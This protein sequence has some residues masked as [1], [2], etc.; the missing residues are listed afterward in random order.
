M[1]LRWTL[2]SAVQGSRLRRFSPAVAILFALVLALA[3]CSPTPP[4]L[5][6]A[7]VPPV[8]PA[9]PPAGGPVPL[10]PVVL[11]VLAEPP[12]A[13]EPSWTLTFDRPVMAALSEAGDYVVVGRSYG[14][15]RNSTQWGAVVYDAATGKELWRKTHSSGYRAIEVGVLGDGPSFAVSLYTYSNSG[16]MWVYDAHGKL[17]WSRAVT[18][19]SWL[20]ANP[21]G[22]RFYGVDRGRSQ[23]FVVDPGSGRELATISASSDAVVQLSPTGHGLVIAGQTL[24]LLS[25]DGRVLA[26]IPVPEPFQDIQFAP[27]GE[28]VYTTASGADSGIYKFDTKGKLIWSAPVPPGGS[29]SLAL[30]PDGGYALVYNVGVEHGFILM[31]AADGTPLHRI[32]LASVEDAKG[33]FIRSVKWL[34]DGLGFLVDHAVARDANGRHT[35]EHSLLWFDLAGQLQGRLELSANVDVLIS[36]DGATC[37]TVT[38]VPGEFVNSNRVRLYDLRPLLHPE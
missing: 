7:V 15:I 28:G 9:S 22:T 38:T 4:S 20:Q 34:P 26:R 27:S 19:S 5:P 1:R 16:T 8:P 3:A 6:T 36:A 12:F 17:A 35:E 30:S 25:R 13:L 21:D 2:G 14:S 32:D 31:D 23:V 29:N 24:I 10:D 18:S 37:V 11:A 33:Q